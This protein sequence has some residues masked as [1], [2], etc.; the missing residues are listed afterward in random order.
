MEHLCEMSNV[1][2]HIQGTLLQVLKFF[3]LQ[4]DH[5]LWDVMRAENSPDFL[6]IDAVELLMCINIC[7]PPVGCRSLELM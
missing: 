5:A 4:L 7:I 3:L 2:A 1:L 6:P